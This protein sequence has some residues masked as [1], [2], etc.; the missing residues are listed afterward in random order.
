M[1]LATFLQKGLPLFSRD[2][3]K[4]DRDST[5]KLSPYLH[6]GEIS[7]RTVYYKVGV[8]ALERGYVDTMCQ[9]GAVLWPLDMHALACEG[10]FS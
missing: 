7:I 10:C 1:T 8:E 2:R 6:Y 3:A 4:T 9:Y 5:S